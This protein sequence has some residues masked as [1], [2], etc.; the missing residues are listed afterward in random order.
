[1]P[2][3]KVI[4]DDA[5]LCDGL[6]ITKSIKRISTL[7]KQKS[8]SDETGFFAC[9]LAQA[10]C[11][12]LTNLFRWS[13]CFCR[14]CR[15]CCAGFCRVSRSRFLR[16]SVLF[17]SLL[18]CCRAGI[19][20]RCRNWCTSRWHCCCSAGDRCCRLG[21]SCRRSRSLCERCTH[22]EG[23]GNESGDQLIHGMVRFFI[24]RRR[25]FLRVVITRAF[26]FL[27]TR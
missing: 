14:F 20:C 9:L 12:L 18:F 27:L 16:F 7:Q 17:C 21:W 3:L 24:G 6:Q 1:M 23:S 5:F 15:S 11:Q 19:F 13:R 25:Q 4:R 10:R 22:S 26:R 2:A 8:G